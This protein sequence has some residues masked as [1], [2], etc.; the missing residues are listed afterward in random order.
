M[1]T[2]IFT[3]PRPNTATASSASSTH[4]TS[5]S[6]Q[7]SSAMDYFTTSR[8]RIPSSSGTPSGLVAHHSPG[9]PALRACR[10]HRA[11]PAPSG[12]SVEYRPNQHLRE[13]HRRTSGHQQDADLPPRRM[14]RNSGQIPDSQARN[15]RVNM[16]RQG[17]PARRSGIAWH[18]TLRHGR[19]GG[20]GDDGT[21]REFGHVKLLIIVLNWHGLSPSEPTPSSG[22]DL[23]H[24]H[25]S[26]HG[27]E[28]GRGQKLVADALHDL[29]VLLALGS[30]RQPLGIGDERAPALLAL[31]H[32][33]PC[34][35]VGELL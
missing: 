25:C 12:I 21:A 2:S 4:T 16:S 11:T 26:F 5:S 13:I 22:F 23:G 6:G 34:E 7:A 15:I 17:R 19:H 32:A 14:N 9:H 28:R 35:H 27:R 20:G 24:A 30:S 1:A 10:R 31:S 33:I 8:S 29:A 3:A 18:P